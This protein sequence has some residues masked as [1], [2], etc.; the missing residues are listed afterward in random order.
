MK[1][2]IVHALFMKLIIELCD[3]S[4][5][6]PRLSGH[7]LHVLRSKDHGP[8]ADRRITLAMRKQLRHNQKIEIATAERGPQPQN[9]ISEGMKP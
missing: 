1:L 3:G 6:I 8:D 2:G 4:Y 7:V 9:C 5:A